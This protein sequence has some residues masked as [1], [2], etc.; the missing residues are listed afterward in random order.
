MIEFAVAPMEDLLPTMLHRFVAGEI[1]IVKNQ[2]GKP[3]L[4]NNEVYFNL[5]HSGNLRAVCVSEA[6]VGIDIQIWKKVNPRVA[7]RCFSQ[8]ELQYLQTYGDEQFFKIWTR[9]ESYLKFLGTGFAKGLQTFDVFELD[10][11]FFE[12]TLDNYYSLCICTKEKTD[13]HRIFLT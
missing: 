7:Q 8:G 4:A 13:V 10:V 6:E 11:Y 9:K 2:Y 1:E 12:V 3:Y 5:S